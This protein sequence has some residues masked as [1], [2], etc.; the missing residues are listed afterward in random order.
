VNEK[1]IHRIEHELL[2][3]EIPDE[4]V[5]AAGTSAAAWTFICAG[6]QCGS[7]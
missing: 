6:I 2:T 3:H 4:A 1:I 5:E 7:V